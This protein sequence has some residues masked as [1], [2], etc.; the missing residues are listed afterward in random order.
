MHPDKCLNGC[1]P[2]AWLNS[3]RSATPIVIANPSA[4]AAIAN[5]P[6][7][8]RRARSRTIASSAGLKNGDAY[9]LA[10]DVAFAMAQDGCLLA[11]RRCWTS[12]Q[13]GSPVATG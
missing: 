5:A 2:E 9:W 3:P 1:C 8:H 7:G 6:H 13:A 12:I 4:R 11:L 10:Y